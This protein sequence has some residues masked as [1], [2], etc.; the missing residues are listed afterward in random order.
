MDKSELPGG[1]EWLE[2]GRKVVH[3]DQKQQRKVHIARRNLPD[4]LSTIAALLDA[5]LRVRCADLPLT[6]K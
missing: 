2:I 5:L 4:R 6:L 1:P 3:N